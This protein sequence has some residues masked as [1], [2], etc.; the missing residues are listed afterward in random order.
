MEVVRPSR[1]PDLTVEEAPGESL[2]LPQ[3]DWD[4]LAPQVTGST[5]GCAGLK[6]WNAPGGNP[7]TGKL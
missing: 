1:S 7:Q 4:P 5:E 3:R 6:L 2:G